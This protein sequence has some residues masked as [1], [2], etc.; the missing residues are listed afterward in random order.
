MA[1]AR[2]A[3]CF[4]GSGIYGQW[5]S[6][7]CQVEDREGRGESRGVKQRFTGWHN[8]RQGRKGT[9][10]KERFKS[11]WSRTGERW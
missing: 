4:C 5:C 3:K 10:W 1:P 11:V 7:R 9:L 8:R 2:F 6:A